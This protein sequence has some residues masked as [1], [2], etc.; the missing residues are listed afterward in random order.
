MKFLP[1]IIGAFVAFGGWHYISNL[2]ADFKTSQENNIVLN[3]SVES[4]SLLIKKINTEIGQIRKIN[5]AVD[6]KVNAH[7][8]ELAALS[9]KFTVSKNKQPRK[10]SNISARKPVLVERIIN[11][12]TVKVLRCME[13]STGA[14][15]KEGEVNDCE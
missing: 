15:L 7:T 11:R 3:A 1:Y 8:K 5:T 4:Q 12:G 6:N 9:N 14:K 10:F 2:R 13:L